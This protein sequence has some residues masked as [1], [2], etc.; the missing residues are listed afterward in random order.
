MTKTRKKSNNKLLYY[1]IGAVVALLLFLI[2]GKSAGWIGKP[3]DLE[4]ELARASR[5]TIVEKVSAS[6]TV[7]PV[8]EVKLA[9]EVSGEIRELL[10]EDGDSVKRGQLLVKIRPDTWLSQLERAE[11]SL[12]Q[13]RANLV[14]AEAALARS[15]AT[16]ERARQEYERQKKLWNEKV[17]SEAEW[18]LAEQNFKVAENDLKSARQQVEAAKYTV[19]SSEATVNEARENVRL[20]S[21]AA[22]M[23]GVISKLN[24]KK[25]ERVVGTAQMQGTEM[26]R[27]A[28]LSK[29]EVRVNVNENDIVRVHI[30]DSAIVDVDAYANTGRKFRGIVTHIANTAKD[31][32]SADAIT[33]FEVRILL[34]SQSYQDLIAEGRK[35][36]FRPGMTASVEII[37]TRKE[38]VLAVPLAAVT[39]RAEEKNKPQGTPANPASNTPAAQP[40][41][42]ESKVVV[43]VNE[44]GV[45]KMK[46]VKTGISDYDFIEI[47]EGITDSTEVVTGPFLVVSKRLKDGDKIRKAEPKEEKKTAGS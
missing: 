9:P 43:F 18:Q 46:E 44:N 21:V 16:F 28:D 37:T 24:V 5:V 17:I 29:M 34:L 22:P 40:R 35:F 30:G 13:Q 20:T 12:N 15:Q 6:G 10:V 8:T 27:I 32:V 7:Q 2:I 14:A 23:D 4:V 26:M 45:A 19:R 1:L 42:E 36:P 41:K 47:T 31:K 3:R 25:G 39:T 11:A 38:N 33:E